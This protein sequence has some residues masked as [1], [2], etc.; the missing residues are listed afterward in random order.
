MRNEGSQNQSPRV[1]LS[2]R[3]Q[4][5]AWRISQGA[6]CGDLSEE[7][8]ISHAV[9]LAYVFG[10]RK[11]GIARLAEQFRQQ[12]LNAVRRRGV[13]A[14]RDSAVRLRDLLDHEDPRLRL[15]AACTLASNFRP[16]LKA[17]IGDAPL[18]EGHAG[19]IT[20]EDLVLQIHEEQVRANDRRN[21]AGVPTASAHP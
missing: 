7:F 21:Q 1:R 11:P 12:A 3:D 9:A 4:K 15:R 8:G 6:T 19:G 14:L 13:Q 2:Q 18:D 16:L 5:I 17:E 20:I 10:K